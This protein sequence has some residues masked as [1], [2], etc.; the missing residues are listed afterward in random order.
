[1]LLYHILLVGIDYNEISGDILLYPGDDL[2]CQ[3]F[4]VILDDT[5]LEDTET[6]A[7][8]IHQRRGTARVN[9]IQSYRTIAIVDD[10]SERCTYVLMI[11]GILCCFYY[12]KIQQISISVAYIGFNQS[13]YTVAEGDGV[14]DVCVEL[15]GDEGSYVLGKPLSVRLSSDGE[16]A[17]GDALTT[18]TSFN[19]L[20]SMNSSH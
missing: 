8:S 10:E 16:T 1:M 9:F 20:P 14:V 17:E 12:V 13:S 11:S 6:F 15:L 18:V 3:S 7:V 2:T 5:I 4:D 19:H